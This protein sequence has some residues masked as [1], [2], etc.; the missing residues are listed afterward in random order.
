MPGWRPFCVAGIWCTLN[1][2]DGPYQTMALIMV[3]A[4]IHSVMSHMHRPR[5]EKR[6]AAIVM[7]EDWEEWLATSNTETARSMLQLRPAEDMAV[8]PLYKNRAAV[9]Q[10]GWWELR[11]QYCIGTLY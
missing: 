11:S 3:N 9:L 7:P 2:A 4:D 10:E 5:H 1:G 6:S 8:D